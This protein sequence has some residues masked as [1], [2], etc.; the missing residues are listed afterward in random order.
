MSSLAARAKKEQPPAARAA[1]D[2]PPLSPA[3]RE[4]VKLAVREWLRRRR[5]AR[6]G[7]RP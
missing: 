5:A 6:V 1:A 3:E 2:L 7:S 4:L